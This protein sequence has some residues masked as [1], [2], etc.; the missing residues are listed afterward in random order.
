MSSWGAP[1]AA[2]ILPVRML[3]TSLMVK[4]ARDIWAHLL[5]VECAC[6]CKTHLLASSNATSDISVADAAPW[7][8]RI[9]ASGATTPGLPLHGHGQ[10]LGPPRVAAAFAAKA[11]ATCTDRLRVFRHLNLSVG[12]RYV[13]CFLSAVHITAASLPVRF[14][15]RVHGLT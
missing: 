13:L 11:H 1:L 8:A 9:L 2:P 5:D 3:P 12:T 10:G 14:T 4:R 7:R 6:K 15:L